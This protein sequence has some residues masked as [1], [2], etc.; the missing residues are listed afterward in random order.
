MA[1]INPVQS[2]TNNAIERYGIDVGGRVPLCVRDSDFGADED[3]EYWVELSD[4]RP[5]DLDADPHLVFCSR[6]NQPDAVTRRD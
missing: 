6:A 4:C 1:V 3:G 2:L 5:G